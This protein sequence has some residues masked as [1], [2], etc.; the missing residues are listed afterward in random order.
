MKQL[1]LLL[2]LLFGLSA[3]TT[4]KEMK[5]TVVNRY[6]AGRQLSSALRE[7]E[8]GRPIAAI[9]I[10]E[11]LVAAPGVKGVTDEGLFRLSVLKLLSADKDGAP[12]AIRYLERL[13]VEYRD[14]V[15]TQQAQPLLEFLKGAAE[16]QKTN[17]T[18][19]SSN[20]SLSRDNRELRK[21]IERLKNLDIQ[22]ERKIR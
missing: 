14:S 9:A 16:T 17:R 11:E 12:A 22:L 6:D 4:V 21:S 1:L 2:L 13:R 5:S 10:M 15:W 19:K 8:Q 20:S 18:L 7:L 3:C